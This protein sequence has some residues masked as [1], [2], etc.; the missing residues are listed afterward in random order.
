M[1]SRMISKIVFNIY[2]VENEIDD[3]TFVNMWI[4][5]CYWKLG[6]D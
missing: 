4:E 1:H 6:R 2:I 3:Y 5:K